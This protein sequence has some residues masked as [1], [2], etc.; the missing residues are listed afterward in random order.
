MDTW[1]IELLHRAAVESVEHDAHVL[2]SAFDQ[3]CRRL[4]SSAVDR[5]ARDVS[6]G[7]V[8]H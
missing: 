5:D 2:D 3:S 8:V 6:C 4:G 1:I 7:A